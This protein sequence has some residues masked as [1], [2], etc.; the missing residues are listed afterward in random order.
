M[1]RSLLFASATAA[2]AAGSAANAQSAP[3]AAQKPITRADYVKTVDA[4]FS[5]TDA[6]HDGVVTKAEI[7]AQQ[8]REM[9]QATARIRQQLQ[10]RFGQLDTN[11]DGQLNL[12]E[13]LA[14]APPLRQA[15]S[16]DQILQRLDTNH[17]G[18]ISADEFRAPQLAKFSGVDA[19]HDGVVTPAEIKAAAG[20]K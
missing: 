9:Q 6:N 12:Q 1:M 13:F 3:A 11:K 17:D 7:V 19:N 15:E 20:K 16:P 14:A 2:L 5:A 18:K 8:Q 4:R 10:V